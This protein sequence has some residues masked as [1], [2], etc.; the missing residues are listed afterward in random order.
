M[1]GMFAALA[2]FAAAMLFRQYQEAGNGIDAT[3]TN[4][5]QN[6][7][8]KAPLPAEVPPYD[9]K[10]G[11]TSNPAGKSPVDAG[12][13]ATEADPGG[14]QIAPGQQSLPPAER[15]TEQM[16]DFRLP[17]VRPDATDELVAVNQ[18]Q[19][20]IS[21]PTPAPVAV[22]ALTAVTG[23]FEPFPTDPEVSQISRAPSYR[24]TD[25]AVTALDAIQAYR[26][27]AA[28]QN[29]ARIEEIAQPIPGI[30]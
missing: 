27:R 29:R 1:V 9:E 14:W 24:D 21:E 10:D 23:G 8:T 25:E 11:A 17:T 7:K 12:I 13:V 2:V 16:A 26:A 19:A 18:T 5:G 20:A 28:A 3:G 4:G 6:G 22:T 15:Q 30:E